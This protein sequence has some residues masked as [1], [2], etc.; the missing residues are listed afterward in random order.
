MGYANS[1]VGSASYTIQV[2]AAAPIFN[3]VAGTYASSQT[4]TLSSTTTGATLYYTIDGT[5]PTTS[6]PSVSNGSTVTVAASETLKAIAVASGYRRQL[7]A[8]F[9]RVKEA[10]LP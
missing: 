6:S 4:V 10:L 1:P 5:T 9:D 2:P 7:F 3:P 8:E